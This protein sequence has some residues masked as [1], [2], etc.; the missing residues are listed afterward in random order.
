MNELRN[1]PWRMLG[2]NEQETADRLLQDQLSPGKWM[3]ASAQDL[4]GRI[5]RATNSPTV[6]GF[7]NANKGD[8]IT[9]SQNLDLLKEGK[10]LPPILKAA[11]EGAD[12]TLAASGEMHKKYD[13][14]IGHLDKI[15]AGVTDFGRLLYMIPLLGSMV[16]GQKALEADATRT[17]E[18]GK[19]SDRTLGPAGPHEHLQ[20]FPL[21]KG[22][23][24]HRPSMGPDP[25]HSVGGALN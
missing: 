24:L 18:M 19:E 5:S 22:S 16:P 7:R 21:R 3:P 9:E 14:M 4:Q 11:G 1:K 13:I 15:S 25:D 12:P 10:A 20:G 2:G 17:R 8:A 6:Q 23:P